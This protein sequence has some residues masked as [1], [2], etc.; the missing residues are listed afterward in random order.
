MDGENIQETKPKQSKIKILFIA[1]IL[2]VG[3]Y[4]VFSDFSQT[5][6]DLSRTTAPIDQKLDEIG[7]ELVGANNKKLVP[8]AVPATEKRPSKPGFI[9]NATQDSTREV[10]N[11]CVKP[12]TYTTANI[13]LGF[14]MTEEDAKSALIE[15]EGIWE[16]KT[17]MNLFDLK[18]SGSLKIS[19]NYDSRQSA[20]DYLT[21][22]ERTYK[23][24]EIEYNTEV[25]YWNERGDAPEDVF[26]E[27]QNKSEDLKQLHGAWQNAIDN[28]NLEI[29]KKQNKVA[30][31][32]WQEKTDF[33][34]NKSLE[35]ER[36]KVYSFTSR[37][38]LVSTLAHE[39]GHALGMEHVTG[40]DSLLNSTS[41]G[42][43]QE[44][45]TQD[46]IELKRVC[47]IIR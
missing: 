43:V 22:A 39:M 5:I 44:P 4:Y 3:L 9:K 27:L 21:A 28:Y 40:K 15:A 19:F 13:D 6:A 37:A 38:E 25:N 26:N 31:Y 14:G 23:K 41:Y 12:I 8:S 7:K 32:E 10:L 29:Q 33:L 20:A 2:I 36:I 46:M 24:A 47:S 35:W 11:R 17:G 34:G 30:E 16:V 45:S 18:D 42:A 1:V